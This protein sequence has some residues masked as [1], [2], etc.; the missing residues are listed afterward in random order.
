MI[1]T[2]LIKDIFKTTVPIISSVSSAT[3]RTQLLKKSLTSS[4]GVY[5]YL[6]VFSDDFADIYD[7]VKYLDKQE[8]IL[9]WRNDKPN[10][11]MIKSRLKASEITSKIREDY[12][13]GRFFVTEITS[14]SAGFE[15]NDAWDF[16][17]EVISGDKEKGKLTEDGHIVT[18]K[19]EEPMIELQN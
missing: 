16:I 13:N 14:N 15:L 12:P 3:E 7:F 11:L 18:N 2:E 17:T 5:T 1:L 9:D 10:S 6:L 19:K 8:S 4:L